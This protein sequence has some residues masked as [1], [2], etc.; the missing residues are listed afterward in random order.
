M[1]KNK[2]TNTTS[3]KTTKNNQQTKPNQP[4]KKTRKKNPKTF[5]KGKDYKMPKEDISHPT[6]FPVVT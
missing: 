2:Q 5:P 1:E 3:N 4:N 6:V